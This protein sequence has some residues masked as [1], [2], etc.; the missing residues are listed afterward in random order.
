MTQKKTRSYENEHKDTML[1]VFEVAN[2]NIK[3][4]VVYGVQ[5]RN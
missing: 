2:H 4:Q 5:I 3:A 1:Y